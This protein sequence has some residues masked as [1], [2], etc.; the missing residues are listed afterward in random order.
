[1]GR[2]DRLSA[3]RQDRRILPRALTAALRKKPF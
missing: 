3:D 2:P 1:M